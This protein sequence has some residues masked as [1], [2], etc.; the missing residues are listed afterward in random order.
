MSDHVD[1]E[2]AAQHATLTEV[3]DGYRAAG[4]V[5]DFF[6]TVDAQV[7]C[8]GCGSVM[9]PGHLGLV[10]A[11]TLAGVSD[12]ADTLTVACTTCPSCGQD[13]TVVLG[14]GRLASPLDAE[15]FSAMSDDG[16]DD[17]ATAELPPD[18]PA[19]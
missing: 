11:R 14:S 6:V 5:G 3:L 18:D 17:R 2:R 19:T 4:Y 12:P 16:I 9:E 10:S 7:E 15:V 1:P 8:A 13:G